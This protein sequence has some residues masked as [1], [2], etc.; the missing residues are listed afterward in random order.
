M[1]SGGA[2]DARS[3]MDG[4]GWTV[5]TGGSNAQGG[6][7][8]GAGL[9]M[10]GLPSAPIGQS[11]SLSMAGFSGIGMLMMVGLFVYFVAKGGRL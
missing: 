6:A 8:N 1:V 3:G 9:D 2:V 10:S 11:S 4:S 7:R 5:S